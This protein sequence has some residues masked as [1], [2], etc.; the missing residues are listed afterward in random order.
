MTNKITYK[1]LYTA[2]EK[3]ETNLS[4]QIDKKFEEIRDVVKDNSEDITV[5]KYWRANITGKLVL[6]AGVVG[7]VV[8]IAKD[9]VKE[10]FNL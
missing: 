1:D 4:N 6:I 3:T 8:S 9:W 5:L 10:K 2:I 7:F